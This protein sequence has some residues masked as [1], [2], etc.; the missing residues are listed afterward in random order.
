MRLKLKPETQLPVANKNWR[1]RL[2]AAH[3]HDYTAAS[4][5]M[6]LAITLAGGL[7]L[8]GSLYALA[9]STPAHL[10]Q[11]VVGVLFVA[12]AAWFPVEI[13]RSKGSISAADA[14]VF[15]VLAVL[16]TPAAVLAAGADGLIGALRSTRRL[17]SR[18][19]TPA[20][21]MASMAVCGLLF[22]ALAPLFTA[23]GLSPA[24]AKLAA[25]L[26]VSLVPFV[27]TTL[28]LMAMVTLKRG[29]WPR[30]KDWFSGFS[31]VAAMYV[32]AALVAG[33]VQLSA[34][35]QG[36]VTLAIIAVAALVVVMLLRAS[37]AK[38]ESEHQAQE[39]RISEAQLEAERNQQRFV[40]AFT[41][42]AIGMAIVEPGGAILRA[43][44]ALCTLLQRSEAQLAGQPFLA[45]LHPSDVELFE[46]QAREVASREDSAAYSIELRCLAGA[47][48]ELWVALHCGRFSDPGSDVDGLIYQLHDITSRQVA[49]S[50]LQHIAFHDSLTDLA[51][52]AYF[53]E[54]LSV[55]VEAS[56]LDPKV[57]FAVMFLDLD[58]FKVINDSLGH[59]A[60][61]ELL[62]EV[63]RR[64]LQCLRPSDLVARLGGD[65]FAVLLRDPCSSDDGL[66][67]AERM[68][69]ALALPV[70]IF[71]NEIVPSASVGITFSD[72]SYRTVD[73]LLRDADLAMYEAKAAGRGRVAIFNR[74]M[75]DRI[76]DKL[77]LEADLRH[78]IGEGEL[79]LS[80]QPLFNLEPYRLVGF[81]ALARW[82]HPTRGPIGP[83][84]FIAVAEEAGQIE[85]L[86]GW[87][88]NKAVE[89]LAA[90][91]RAAP[92]MAH[93]GMSVNISGRDLAQP[94]F[95]PRVLAVLQRHGVA[96][97]LLTL[98]ITESVLMS[99][100]TSARDTLTRLRSLGVQVAI[101]DFGTGYSSLAYL[102]TLPIDCLKIDRSFVTSLAHGAEN[103]EI[104]RAVLTLGRALAKRVVAE[105]IETPEQLDTLR[106]LGLHVGQGFLLAHPM[107][108]D[109]VS[110]FLYTPATLPA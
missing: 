64:L 1:E 76:A 96:P 56:R 8:A 106:R 98:E 90:W 38:N 59:F 14:F 52:R 93:T 78:A 94:G 42:A 100:L 47:G 102:S 79:S 28:P 88:L 65:E 51:N 81:E 69:A 19:S 66:Q 57:H 84:V 49:E 36:P 44:K 72:M 27:L 33:I 77:S 35:P 109:Q 55:A 67:L 34:L 12:V 87:V 17:T 3:F 75:H 31:W 99:H 11:T 92:H 15:T 26:L 103:V 89:Q 22:E 29:E 32:V 7:A 16:G 46:R 107:R 110:A 50:R 58:R 60:G 97:N 10:L 13:P 24:T 63:G 70:L 40:A 85:A 39:A 41:E 21:A 53:H 101:D 48:G 73:E 43:N 23:W 30:L 82:V 104:V 37:I 62:R 54:K 18:V 2:R 5:R 68:L 80:F 91:H 105:G 74:T 108:A 71:G 86:T 61:N 9:A 20:A 25:L 45:V 6:W 83:T 95:L 4:F